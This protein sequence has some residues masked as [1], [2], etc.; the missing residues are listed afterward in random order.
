MTHPLD[1]LAMT[2]EQV[3]NLDEAER[4]EV[5]WLREKYYG[6]TTDAFDLAS[7]RATF[8]C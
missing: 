1:Y 4:P 3:G 6:W 5:E 7:T 2:E 8:D